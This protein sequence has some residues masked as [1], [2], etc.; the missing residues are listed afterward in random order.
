M[1][2]SDPIADFIVC[3][4]NASMAKKESVTLPSSKIKARIAEILKEEGFIKN[5]KV[6]EEGPKRFIRIYLKYLRGNRPAIRKLR[7]IST[8]G[9]RRYVEAGRIPRVL[10]GLG[11][12]ILSTSKGVVSGKVARQDNIGGEVICKVW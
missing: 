3:V 12:V 8:P 10:N 11:I 1:S 5:F 4:Q 9:L 7:K 2:I 6:V